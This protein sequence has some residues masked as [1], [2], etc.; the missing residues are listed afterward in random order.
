MSLSIEARTRIALACM[1][2]FR[3]LG[4]II[5]IP[6]KFI[7]AASQ[8]LTSISKTVFYAELESARRYKA[9]TGTD[10]GYAIGEVGRYGGLDPARA[11][12]SQQR[13]FNAIHFDDE[14][15]DE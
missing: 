3:L 10:L 1:I 8:V 14:E 4:D 11:E 6:Q 7:D 13:L 12:K 15:E 5:E 2:F 9:L